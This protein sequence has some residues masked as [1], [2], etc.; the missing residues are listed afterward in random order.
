MFAC[1]FF[2]GF[3]FGGGGGEEET[4]RGDT[5]YVELE[6]SLRD[7]YL[8]ASIRVVRDKNVLVPAP[9]TRKCNCKQ[10]VVTQQV[11]PGM[12][13]QYTHKVC[14]DCPAV[15]YERQRDAV[16]VGVEPGM[17]EAHEIPFFE[18][19]EPIVDGEPGDLI[20]TL[21]TQPHPRF[22][23]QGD[24][25][26]VEERISLVDALTGFSR[27][28]EHVDGHMVTLAAAG[29]TSFGQVVRIPGEGMPVFEK[30]GARGDLY[31]RYTV[32]FPEKLSEAQKKAVRELFAAAEWRHDEL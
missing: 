14:E 3:G 28:L 17:P 13:Q 5:I 10:K 1:R 22:A 7:L 30:A 4:P 29:V 27:E 19:G 20:F 32:A 12:Y 11:G 21:R 15:K 26:H 6:V 24:D 16:A 2:G 31:V 8:G 18:E 25:L 9:G 23:R